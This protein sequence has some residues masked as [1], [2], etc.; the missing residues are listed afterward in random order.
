MIMGI[1][2]DQSSKLTKYDRKWGLLLTISV[3]IYGE[4]AM[5]AVWRRGGEL[6]PESTQ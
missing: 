3:V 4:L 1:L 2:K 5:V 6:L